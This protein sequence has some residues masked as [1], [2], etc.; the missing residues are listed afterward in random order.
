MSRLI[1]GI[2]SLEMMTLYPII[3]LTLGKDHIGLVCLCYVSS[4][5]VTSLLT[6]RLIWRYRPFMVSRAKMASYSQTSSFPCQSVS[7]SLVYVYMLCEMYSTV[8]DHH[9]DT[10]TTEPLPTGLSLLVYWPIFIL[11][12]TIVMTVSCVKVAT[13]ASYPS[14]CLCGVVQGIVAC[15]TG[16]VIYSY[17][18]IFS[19]HQ[20]TNQ[21][22]FLPYQFVDWSS[23]LVWSGVMVVVVGVASLPAILLMKDLYRIAGLLLPS[24]A[25]LVMIS[26]NDHVITKSDYRLDARSILIGGFMW[27][28]VMAISNYLR[29]LTWWGRVSSFLIL[30]FVTTAILLLWKVPHN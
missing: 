9:G 19:T 8:D 21:T 10:I 22:Y 2:T 27:T 18:K 15:Y 23:L 29:P 11:T 28:V 3:L 7:C 4:M 24:Y 1:S 5:C 17:W 16:G 20:L 13:G 12:V 25:I 14:D 6:K 26:N 30:Y